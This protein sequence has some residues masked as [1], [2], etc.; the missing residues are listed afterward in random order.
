MCESMELHLGNSRHMPQDIGAV[1]LAGGQGKR[2]GPGC[3]KV[4]RRVNGRPMLLRVMQVAAQLVSC[5][6]VVMSP[7][8]LRYMREQEPDIATKLESHENVIIVEQDEPRGTGDAAL[9]G[10]RRLPQRVKRCLILS[11]DTPLLKA[12]S[13][14]NM[15]LIVKPGKVRGVLGYAEVSKA[16]EA[17]GYGR[18]VLEHKMFAVEDEGPATDGNKVLPLLKQVIEQK[19]LLEH[20]QMEGTNPDEYLIINAGV[21]AADP[22][23]LDPYLARLEPNPHTKESYLPDAFVTMARDIP[24]SVACSSMPLEQIINVNTPKDLRDA[25]DAVFLHTLDQDLLS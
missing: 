24:G 17:F 3:P 13:L 11:G 9:L 25:D 4:F 6:V 12:N 14:L 18:V 8:T 10:I 20:C 23:E 1:I 7:N 21:Y 16:D 19:H 22:A 2:M 15:L 5:L